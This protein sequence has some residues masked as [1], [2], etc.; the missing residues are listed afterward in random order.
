MPLILGDHIINYING[1][2][3]VT[4]LKPKRHG[5]TFILFGE[6]HSIQYY[7]ECEYEDCLELQT[8][9]IEKLNDF[10][11][12]YPTDFFLEDF[13]KYG[14]NTL[15]ELESIDETKKASVKQI[16]WEV[17]KSLRQ[18]KANPTEET[19]NKYIK[20]K[21]ATRGLPEESNMTQMGLLYRPCFFQKMKS[22][23]NCPYKNIRW[24]YADVRDACLYKKSCGTRD[25]F[26][27]VAYYGHNALR[28]VIK[29]FL[30][31]D[32]HKD[33]VYNAFEDFDKVMFG[34][35]KI[36]LL[37]SDKHQ[38]VRE[39]L[40]SPF[41]KKQYDKTNK[42]IFT[43]I[44]FVHLFDYYFRTRNIHDKM[45]KIIGLVEKIRDYGI[46]INNERSLSRKSAEYKIIEIQEDELEKEL[47]ILISSN[48]TIPLTILHHLLFAFFLDIYFI[49][50]S[51]DNSKLTVGYFGDE[52]MLGI[53]E[54]FANIIQTHSVEFMVRQQPIIGQINTP[55]YIDKVIEILERPKNKSRS[56]SK[57]KPRRHS[58][59]SFRSLRAKPVRAKSI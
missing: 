46:I 31:P 24:Q 38:F 17:T 48:Q 55:I 23:E 35:E 52:H 18:Y 59:P 37:L 28:D 45:Q 54:Y 30:N 47:K 14:D 56:K 57:S 8:T 2:S 44:S 15:M 27:E 21:K 40:E 13:F 12:D 26:L 6:R 53:T 32:S 36:I 20:V 1:P 39:L 4:I 11:K 41:F 22:L 42:D 49:L 16:A 25:S 5:N 9:F 50:R 7:S 43:V 51:Y 33:D 10:A 29:Y 58:N 34:F 19:K 3:A